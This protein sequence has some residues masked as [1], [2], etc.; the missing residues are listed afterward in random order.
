MAA[1]CWDLTALD[2]DYA[3]WLRTYRPVL[4]E[5]RRGHVDPREA[6]ILRTR[7]THDYRKFPFRDPDLPV[8]LLPAGWRGREAHEVFLQAHEVL[9]EPAE[10]FVD[11]IL[12]TGCD[13]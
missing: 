13:M 8:E 6:L 11:E 4:R 12:N 5:L 9:R 2:E 10:R 3:T 7:M 1:R